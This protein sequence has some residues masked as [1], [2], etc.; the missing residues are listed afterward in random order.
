MLKERDTGSRAVTQS[1]NFIM[2]DASDCKAFCLGF[3]L[4]RPAKACLK[5]GVRGTL[6][7]G[8]ATCDKLASVCNP[9]LHKRIVIILR[10]VPVRAERGF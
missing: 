7:L 2:P 3:L 1:L 10:R 6:C 9:S 4:Q 8:Q 5:P